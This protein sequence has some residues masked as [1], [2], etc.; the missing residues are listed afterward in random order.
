MSL[1]L[2]KKNI[3]YFVITGLIIY[4]LMIGKKETVKVEIPKKT[5]SVEINDPKPE[6]EVDT[7][8][9]DSTDYSKG[10]RVVEVENPVNEE[11]LQKYNEAIK[12]NDSLKQLSLYKEAIKERNYTEKLEDSVQIITVKS[13]VVGTLKKQVISYETKP[14]TITFKTN[15]TKP[16]FYI[17]GFAN[18]PT[19]QDATP[20]FGLQIQIAN[21]KRVLTGGIDNKKQI[22]IGY[23][24]KLF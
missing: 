20:S 14:Q 24:I 1:I 17:G 10:F 19:I 12:A 11:L 18:L 22:H 8:Y 4:I 21:K 6:K 2:N 9:V 3:P 5:G 7:V 15:R 13:E 16:V 23:A